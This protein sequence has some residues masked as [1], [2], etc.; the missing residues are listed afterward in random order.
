VDAHGSRA[1]QPHAADAPLRV[2]ADD[3]P[4][5]TG[6]KLMTGSSAMGST[7]LADRAIRW[8]DASARD[9]PWGRPDTSAWGVLV[10]EVMLQQTPVARV[11]PVYEEWLRRWPTA[12]RLAAEPPG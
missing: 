8:Y 6:Q 9:L 3:P 10:S 5:G 7:T 1:H 2:F 4:G 12:A 11:T